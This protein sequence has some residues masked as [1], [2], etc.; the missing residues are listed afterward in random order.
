MA[1]IDYKKTV[2]ADLELVKQIDTIKQSF[3]K[4]KSDLAN[5]QRENQQLKID[6]AKVN[7]ALM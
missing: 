1:D 3:D 4:D 6:L 2:S 5:A 7:Q